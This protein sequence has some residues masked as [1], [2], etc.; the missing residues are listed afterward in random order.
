MSPQ[1]HKSLKMKR[2]SI[3]SPPPQLSGNICFMT[4]QAHEH[5][6]YMVMCYI[7]TRNL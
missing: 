2:G 3:V 1:V 6:F 7:T 4:F 5:Y